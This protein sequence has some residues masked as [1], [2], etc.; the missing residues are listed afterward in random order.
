MFPNKLVQALQ[1][2]KKSLLQV[3]GNDP[4][5]FVIPTTKSKEFMIG[6]ARDLCRLHWDFD[7]K[8]DESRKNRKV[9]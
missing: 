6:R 8:L 7:Q 2:T 1:F 4:V 5:S 3:Y 9:S